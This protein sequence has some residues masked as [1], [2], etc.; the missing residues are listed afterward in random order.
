[1][2]L[3]HSQWPRRDWGCPGHPCKYA[4][5]KLNRWVTLRLIWCLVQT[6]KWYKMW[7]SSIWLSLCLRD[8]GEMYFLK[9][10]S[11]LMWWF[12]CLFI[13][14]ELYLL[15]HYFFLG[16]WNL[17]IILVGNPDSRRSPLKA[18]IWKIILFGNPDSRGFLISGCVNSF[19]TLQRLIT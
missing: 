9:S 18:P 10:F 6:P 5:T 11:D 19:R 3:S 4:M 17:R 7:I 2:L 8:I 1:V 16:L 15:I 13:V 14:H 12:T